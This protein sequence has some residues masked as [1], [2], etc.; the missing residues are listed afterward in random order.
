M[1]AT[2]EIKT[3]APQEALFLLENLH[4]NQRT[5]R[6]KA[7]SILEKEMRQGTFKLSTDAILILRGKLGNGQHRL[8]A[9]VQSGKPQQ[10]LVLK[11]ND[12]SIFKVLDCGI[13]RTI[14]DAMNLANHTNV[15]AAARWIMAIEAG[16]ATPGSGIANFNVT[17]SQIMQFIETNIELLQ[18]ASRITKN[19]YSKSFI[20]N[21]AI[22]TAF[23][24]IA[25][26]KSARTR[27]AAMELLV[28]VYTG[29]NCHGP[30][31]DLRNRMITN[32]GSKAKLS[33]AY[34]MGLLIKA[35]IDRVNGRNATMLRFFAGENY[36]KFPVL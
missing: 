7:V 23:L 33:Q 12:E 3:I 19:L 17:R 1:N 11:T 2:I 6:T 8:T 29:E 24:C 32:R 15:T 9:V 25:E 20:L 36:P 26:R 4:D 14:G 27:H 34:I 18:D 5:I 28:A 35:F 10:F 22:A 21:K 31:N 16:Q 13:R 30:A